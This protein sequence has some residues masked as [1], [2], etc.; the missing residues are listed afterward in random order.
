MTDC[1]QKTNYLKKFFFFYVHLQ[2]GH[3]S[4]LYAAPNRILFMLSGQE[5]HNMS[6]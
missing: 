2:N 6:I 1:F 4:F 5:A 3:P